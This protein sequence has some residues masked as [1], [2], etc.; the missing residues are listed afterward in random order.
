MSSQV[1]HPSQATCMRSDILRKNSISVCSESVLWR[2]TSE[3]LKS[4]I[5]YS[6]HTQ[7]RKYQ[8]NRNTYMPETSWTCYATL[9]FKS[10]H[11]K[12]TRKCKSALGL[13]GLILQQQEHLSRPYTKTYGSRK[14]LPQ[15]NIRFAAPNAHAAES[16]TQNILLRH[17][18][19]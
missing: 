10:S 13:N 17:L 12:K 8:E 14:G 18:S 3:Y 11:I 15:H 9:C 16:S 7:C 19:L 1:L 4:L 6:T 2:N 5:G